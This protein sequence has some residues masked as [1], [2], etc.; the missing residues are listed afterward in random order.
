MLELS[1]WGYRTGTF[2]LGILAECMGD[3]RRFDYHILSG[4]EIIYGRGLE[5]EVY[6]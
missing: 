1:K 6:R 2:K 4:A 5:T 3:F